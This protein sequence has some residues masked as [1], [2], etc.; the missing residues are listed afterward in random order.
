MQIGH[1]KSITTL[2][3][4]LAGANFI[5]GMGMQE[6]G[7]TFC[8]IQLLIDDML[9]D[10][11]K[12]IITADQGV[13]KLADSEWLNWLMGKGFPAEFSFSPRVRGRLFPTDECK[14]YSGRP[15]SLVRAREKAKAILNHHK[16]EPLP[17]FV[18]QKIREIIL[19][20]EEKNTPNY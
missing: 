15:D 12:K 16:P 5:Y 10:S 19:E 14:S 13:D 4:A 20:V 17:T 11:I 7:V 1:E 3:P 6:L 18:R 9:V 8:F 2:L